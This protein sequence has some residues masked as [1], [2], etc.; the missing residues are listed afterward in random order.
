MQPVRDST[1]SVQLL[2]E[3]VCNNSAS[4]A[5]SASTKPGTTP[6]ISPRVAELTAVL[7]QKDLTDLKALAESNHVIIRAFETL[8][9]ILDVEGNREGAEWVHAAVEEER[10]RIQHAVGFLHQ[11]CDALQQRGCPVTVIKSLDH[12]PDLG[13]DLDLYT[14]AEA[15]QIVYV[16]TSQFQAS[17]ENRSWGDRLANKWN[18]V[19]PG[20]PELVEVHVGRLGQTGEQIAV[21]RSVSTRACPKN[22]GPFSFRVPAP[23]D[24]IIISTLQRMYRH[25]YIRLC[26]IV[27]NA[28]LLDQHL[29]DFEYLHSVAAGAGLWDGIA[30]Y[31][32]IISQ[33]ME[34]YRGYGV[35]LPSLV[36]ASA[37]FGAAEIRFRRQFLRV[38][39]LPHSIHLYAGELK[40]L[41]M[42]GDF[43]NGLR[44]SLLPGLATAAALEQKLTG[45]DK[46]IW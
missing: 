32:N 8:G 11:I 25:F 38:P 28:A 39:I 16:M 31:L 45:S 4:A 17:L 21:T 43:R 2:S 27:D 15:A 20:L 12:W 10:S 37:K 36:T 26:D 22:V 14:D 13:S 42:N 3:L 40:T 33:Y 34:L 35:P 9:W 46:G 18:F 7:T 29:V 5:T 41:L 6:T 44:L 30:T 24:R 23:E 1:R 19:V